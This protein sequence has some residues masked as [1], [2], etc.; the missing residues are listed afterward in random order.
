[1]KLLGLTARLSLGWPHGA[2]VV[3]ILL[4]GGPRTHRPPALRASQNAPG[5]VPEPPTRVGGAPVFREGGPRRLDPRQ[6]D[7]RIRDR[8]GDALLERP[9][10]GRVA[11]PVHPSA[12]FAW[13]GLGDPLAPL[14]ALAEVVE[15]AAALRVEAPEDL[16]GDPRPAQL[17]EA[18]RLVEVA[19]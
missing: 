2:G 11:V 14:P 7:T 6:G 4:Q 17:L 10:A 12:G 5:E 18:V 19:L 15:T 9:S 1:M 16:F 8:H 3:E 13:R